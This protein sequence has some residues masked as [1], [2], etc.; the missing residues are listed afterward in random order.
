MTKGKPWT[1]EE[2]TTL[3]ALVEANTPL[4][5]MA[6]KLLKRPE[7]VYVKCTRLGL[8]RK[9]PDTSSDIQQ[10]KDLPS[11][12]EILKKLAAAADTASV[13]GLNR[14]EIQRLHV[15]SKLLKD[16]IDGLGNYMKYSAIETKLNNMEAKYDELLKKT[17]T[18]DA[19]KPV[20][21]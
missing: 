8:T 1:I 17:G 16:Y 9:L 7:A 12:E 2:E 20:S 11:V 5:I 4:E 15:L 10:P 3:K 13:P 14:N 6:A 19:S 18:D 21:P